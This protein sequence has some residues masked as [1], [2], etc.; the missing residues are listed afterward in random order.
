MEYQQTANQ[1]IAIA[2]KNAWHNQVFRIQTIIGSLVLVAMLAYMPHF[3]GMMEKRQGIVLNDLLLQQLPAIDVSVITFLIIW[4]I[5]FLLIYRSVQDPSVFIL[6]LYTLILVNLIRFATISMTPLDPPL[7]LVP[8]RDPLSS[9]FYGGPKI[10]ITKDLFFS[11]HT[12]SQ[13]MVFLCLKNRK[14]KLVALV[15]S[16]VVGLLVL[17]QHVHYTI[18]VAAAFLATYLAFWL[19]G[20]LI[21]GTGN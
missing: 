19:A 12:S 4:S 5:N 15:A 14:D 21:N 13:F 20:K 8:L 17:I 3:F 11:G 16:I 9:L 18:D 6:G 1:A 10:F 2:W 7:G